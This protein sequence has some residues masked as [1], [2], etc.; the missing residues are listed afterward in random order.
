M[1]KSKIKLNEKIKFENNNNYDRIWKNIENNN[2]KIFIIDKKQLTYNETAILCRLRSEHIEINEYLFRFNQYNSD[3]CELCNNNCIENIYHFLL[4]CPYYNALRNVLFEELKEKSIIFNGNPD[5][6]M[7]YFDIMA[8]LYP[9]TLQKELY[10]SISINERIYI[11]KCIYKYVIKSKRFENNNNNSLKY[12]IYKNMYDKNENNITDEK[13][14]YYNNLL[15]SDLINHN[16]E[17]MNE[18]YD[19]YYEYFGYSVNDCEYSDNTDD[20]YNSDSDIIFS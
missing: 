13:I 5:T 14:N 2:N 18:E 8:Y 16:N 3:K 1:N 6:N 4:E 15:N 19:E 7:N 9:H 10:S 11:Y 17:I 20:Q 12:N